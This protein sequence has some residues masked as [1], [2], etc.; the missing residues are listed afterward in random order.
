MNI[1][2]GWKNDNEKGGID[3]ALHHFL[4]VFDFAP[5]AY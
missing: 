5:Y 4:S 3:L 2:K 1:L